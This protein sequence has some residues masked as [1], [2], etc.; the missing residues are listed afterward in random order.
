MI[1]NVYKIQIKKHAKISLRTNQWSIHPCKMKFLKLV[2]SQNLFQ[3]SFCLSFKITAVFVA[4]QNLLNVKLR[5]PSFII[6]STCMHLNSIDKIQDNFL[7][8]FACCPRSISKI[9]NLDYVIITKCSIYF[10]ARGVTS[11]ELHSLII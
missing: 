9:T 3:T 11:Q 10:R 1:N 8:L 6:T 5:F 2:S 4:L 7:S